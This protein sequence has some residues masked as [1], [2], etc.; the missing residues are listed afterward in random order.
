[1]AESN[2][3]G[4]FLR[5]LIPCRVLGVLFGG[6]ALFDIYSSLHFALGRSLPNALIFFGAAG[7]H[8]VLAYGFWMTRKWVV[9]IVGIAIILAVSQAVIRAIGGAGILW[10]VLINLAVSVAIFLSVFFSR[11]D[12]Q[13]EYK[14]VPMIGLFTVFLIVS[15]VAIFFLK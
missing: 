15:E 6:I 13:G 10:Q 11:K 2:A 9:S 7:M 1:M 12:L 5:V 8:G 4:V 3:Q 14:D